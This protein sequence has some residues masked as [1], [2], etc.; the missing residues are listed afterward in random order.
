VS[1][2]ETGLHRGIT[3]QGFNLQLGVIQSLLDH[4]TD[5]DEADKLTV[6]N[7]RKMANSSLGHDVH[8]LGYGVMARATANIP[9][10]HITDF[11]RQ[12]IRS[13]SGERPYD[14]ALGYDAA[15]RVIAVH[16]QNGA[17]PALG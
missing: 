14:V 4:V 17:N 9:G 6:I 7:N 11:L 12:D 2:V 16:H 15:D 3:A 10:H 13:V 1:A 8:D 5:A